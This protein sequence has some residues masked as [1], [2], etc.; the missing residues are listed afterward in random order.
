MAITLMAQMQV[1]IKAGAE[2]AGASDAEAASTAMRFKSLEAGAATQVWGATAPELDSHG[3]AYLA[4]CQVGE[5]GGNVAEAGVA[6]HARDAEA[7]K[8]LWDL[9]EEWV[10]QQF[11]C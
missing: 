9:S 5:L 2:E 6:P 1:H 11:E 8:Q 4:N 10:G 7:A 3:G